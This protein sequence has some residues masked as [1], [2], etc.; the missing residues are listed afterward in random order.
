MR[1]TKQELDALLRKNKGVTVEKPRVFTKR[2]KS[3]IAANIVDPYSL[4]T[5]SLDPETGEYLGYGSK[6]PDLGH[7]K[8]P[9]MDLD[10]AKQDYMKSPYKPL[11]SSPGAKEG[12]SGGFELYLEG[13]P[14]SKKNSKQIISI[15]CKGGKRRPMLISSKKYL[16]WEK[17]AMGSFRRQYKGDI[18]DYPI[19][20]TC[21]FFYKDKRIWDLNNKLEGLLDA[22][23][24]IVIK[25]DHR[26]IVSRLVI[27]QEKGEVARVKLTIE[28]Y[29]N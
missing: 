8:P 29:E 17:L 5:S 21:T 23:R 14:P 15:P 9:P 4:G 25:D 2:Q 16:E 28:N 6:P 10:E 19:S 13:I 1:L 18:I 12:H 20:I 26:F 22:L 27:G 3:L 7:C 24:G 11:I